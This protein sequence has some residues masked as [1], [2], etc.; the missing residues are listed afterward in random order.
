MSY[1]FPAIEV[2]RKTG[3][4]RL[5]TQT[6]NL[7][8]RLLDFWQWSGSDLVSNTMR[9]VFAEYLIAVALDVAEGI[10]VEWDA[11]DVTSKCGM[12]VEVKSSAYLQSWPQKR[13]SAP[14]FGIAPAKIFDESGTQLSQDRKRRS[15]VYVFALLA[16]RDKATIDPLNTDQWDF[17]VVPTDR[18]DEELGDQKS[19]SLAR[20]QLIVSE[21][22]KFSELRASLEAVFASLRS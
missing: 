6:G 21:P 3:Q 5:R 2:R 16:H 19:V 15:D 17:Y 10:R 22:L 1:T 8:E 13:L 20:L 7:P 12:R 4:E 9:G 11:F 18:L 14:V